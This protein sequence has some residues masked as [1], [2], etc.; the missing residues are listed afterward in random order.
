LLNAGN[1]NARLK[2]ILENTS[3]RL[4]YHA[5]FFNGKHCSDGHQINEI[6]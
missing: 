2:R 4:T 1:G 6:G 5:S 3:C